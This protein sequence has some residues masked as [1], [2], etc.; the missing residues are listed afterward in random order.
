M[1][2]HYQLTAIQNDLWIAHELDPGNPMYNVGA[3]DELHGSLQI[4]QFKAAAHRTYLQSDNLHINFIET[5][6]GPKQYFSP[7]PDWQ[8]LFVDLSSEADP[9]AASLNWIKVDMASTMDL[10]KDALF[11]F[12]LFKLGAESFLAYF[13][14]HHIISDGLSC[15]LFYKNLIESYK[16]S[17][18]FEAE[19]QPTGSWLDVLEDEQEYLN[20][21]R[22]QDDH[23]YWKAQLTNHP[24]PA[25][26]SGKPPA[27]LSCRQP[28]RIV[29]SCDPEV[30]EKLQAQ[31]KANGKDFNVLIIAAAILY[32]HKFSG[33]QDLLLGI[34]MS[35]RTNRKTRFVLGMQSNIVPLRMSINP[36]QTLADTLGQVAKSMRELLRHQRY[37]VNLL[38]KELGH[39]FTKNSAFYGMLVNIMPFEYKPEIQG[40]LTYKTYLSNGPV[41]DL[42]FLAT[43]KETHS[44]R[45]F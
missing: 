16:A 37:P 42:E 28:I 12:C 8:L 34:P 25:T 22:F 3:C 30:F 27:I 1:E 33:D 24:E 44:P 29:E 41:F 35:A 13:R 23:D 38:R 5:L 43:F 14:C 2:T 40:I 11:S 36:E 6:D 21:K 39:Y 26:L 4:D 31:V 17:L 7:N 20:S 10:T 15:W 45:I 18:G 32:L 9:K 19:I